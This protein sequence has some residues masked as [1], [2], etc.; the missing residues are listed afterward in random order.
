VLAVESVVEESAIGVDFV[1]NGVSV[2]L[3]T[4]SEHH[5]FPL[6]LHLLQEGNGVGADIKPDFEGTAV[7][8]DGEPDVRRAFVLLE[9]VD[10]RLI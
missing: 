2:A 3:V 8:G 6:L 9:A 7:D 4:G 5:H 1:Q 10:E